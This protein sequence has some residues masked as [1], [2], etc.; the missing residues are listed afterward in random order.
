MSTI[1]HSSN[2]TYTPGD[3]PTDSPIKPMEDREPI[4]PNNF[5]NKDSIMDAS[6]G[7]SHSIEM[8]VF[9]PNIQK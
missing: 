9:H 6:F 7:R 4:L 5:R 8:P 3:E 1:I 2:K